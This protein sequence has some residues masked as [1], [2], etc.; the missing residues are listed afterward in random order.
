[1]QNVEENTLKKINI[2]EKYWNILQ[3]VEENTLKK[4][5]IS[6]KCWNILQNVEKNTLKKSTFPKNVG[7]EKCWNINRWKRKAGWRQKKNKEI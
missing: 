5:N 4:L 7:T 6:E 1:L 3:N 2:S